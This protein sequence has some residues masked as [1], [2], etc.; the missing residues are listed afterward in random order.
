SQP[1]LLT[2]GIGPEIVGCRRVPTR[3]V[4]SVGHVSDRHLVHRPARKERREKPPAY[5]T[6]QAAHAI[7]G[8]ASA[9]RQMR[10][11]E[12]LR[13]VSWILT[14]QRKQV[15]GRDAELLPRVIA[16]R[17]FDKGRSETVETGS[18]RRVGRKEIARSRNRQS[19]FER[20]AG[21]LHE[22]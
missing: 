8:P 15:V 5:L 14:P 16:Q 21:L 4:N 12:M 20:L 9:D 19:D 3:H 6:V 10:H 1:T 22:T 2:A 7:Y 17:A 11:T 13:R 18:H